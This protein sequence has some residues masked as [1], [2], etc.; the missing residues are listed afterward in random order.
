[1][2]Y[3]NFQARLNPEH[4]QIIFMAN[5]QSVKLLNNA[6]QNAGSEALKRRALQQQQVAE[7]SRIAMQQKMEEIAQSRWDAQTA[8]NNAMEEIGMGKNAVADKNANTNAAKVASK[9]NVDDS[10][11]NL[12]NSKSDAIGKKL[13]YVTAPDHSSHEVYGNFSDAQAMQKQ[14]QSQNPDT[15]F[16]ILD[17]PDENTEKTV[18]ADGTVTYLSPTAKANYEAHMA[19]AN[20]PSR[21]PAQ[22]DTVTTETPADPGSPAIPATPGGFFSSPTPGTPAVPPTPKTTIVSHRPSG[23]T[24]YPAPPLPPSV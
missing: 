13:W 3:Q 19:E 21:M 1:M 12:N 10:T 22:G 17:K 20:R 24:G 8:H 6:L 7:M 2:L 18:M 15:D 14:Q 5:I 9:S 11:A 23:A 4:D 16:Q